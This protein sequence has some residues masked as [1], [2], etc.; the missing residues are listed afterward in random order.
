MSFDLICFFSVMSFDFVLFR[1]AL[2]GFE[3]LGI[4]L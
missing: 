1:M 4:S 2:Y 3:R